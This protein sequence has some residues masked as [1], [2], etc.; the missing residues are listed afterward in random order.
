ML[1][2]NTCSFCPHE[3]MEVWKMHQALTIYTHNR[4]EYCGVVFKIPSQFLRIPKALLIA[5]HTWECM[6]CMTPL[7]LRICARWDVILNPNKE[8]KTQVRSHN[9]H[10]PSNIFLL[11]W[12]E[13]KV[14]FNMHS[15]LYCYSNCLQT[16]CPPTM[17]TR[18]SSHPSAFY[19]MSAS[20]KV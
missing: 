9:K 18:K 8:L 1:S 14:V 12:Y 19:S 20:P 5:F 6:L 15:I 10:P 2:L 4:I 13:V 11:L 17:T 3:V 7:D 16:V